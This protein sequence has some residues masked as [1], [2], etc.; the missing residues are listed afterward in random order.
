MLLGSQVAGEVVVRPEEENGL[1]E[2]LTEDQVSGDV[3][4]DGM[5]NI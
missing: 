2:G 1:V 4:I 5:E 3:L